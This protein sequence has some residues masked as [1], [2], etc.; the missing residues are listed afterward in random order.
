[1]TRAFTLIELAVVVAVLAI[2]SLIAVPHFLE[3]QVRSK[4]SR[5]RADL[6]TIHTALEAY[7]ADANMYPVGAGGMALAG[8]LYRLTAPNRYLTSLPTDVFR[9]GV[10]YQY[11]AAGG[12]TDIQ[13]ERFGYF[14]MASVGPDELEDTTLVSTIT[15]DPTNG[16]RSI[17]DIVVSSRGE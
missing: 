17:G 13:L 14:V 6:R 16:T 11:Y 9:P 3:A 4:V 1:V 2:L 10:I 7:A 12:V 5:A 15:Y 8:T